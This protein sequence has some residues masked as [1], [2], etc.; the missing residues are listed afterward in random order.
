MSADVTYRLKVHVTFEC[1][2]DWDAPTGLQ[3]QE[4]FMQSMKDG[5]VTISDLELDITKASA[6]VVSYTPL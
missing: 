1:D 3:A 2:F 4:E 6:E 5:F